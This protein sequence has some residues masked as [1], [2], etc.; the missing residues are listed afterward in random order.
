[1]QDHGPTFFATEDHTNAV[2]RRRGH[3]FTSDSSVSEQRLSFIH[4]GPECL[5]NSPKALV[6][7]ALIRKTAIPKGEAHRL[8]KKVRVSIGAGG[9][10]QGRLRQNR[11]LQCVPW[12]F[13]G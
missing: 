8:P 13:I 5:A 3:A 12:D 10:S 6:F 1:V 7:Q 2:R 4:R 11:L 9:R